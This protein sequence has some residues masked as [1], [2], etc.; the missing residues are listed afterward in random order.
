MEARAHPTDRASGE[1][2]VGQ[3]L[4]NN[5]VTLPQNS[6]DTQSSGLSSTSIPQQPV[7]PTPQPKHPTPQIIYI[8]PPTQ[9]IT[10]SNPE[11]VVTSAPSTPKTIPTNQQP[12]PVVTSAP[13]TPKTT[14]TSQQPKPVVTPPPVNSLPVPEEISQV[15]QTVD[16]FK[17]VSGAIADIQKDLGPLFGEGDD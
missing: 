1:V 2:T 11:P 9:S 12:E 10:V 7:N 4:S 13:S 6:S 17:Q 16:S 15:K 3:R 5:E 8:T 14:P